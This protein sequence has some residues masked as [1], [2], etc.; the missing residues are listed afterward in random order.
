GQ[1]AV[2][3]EVD[4]RRTRYLESQGFRVIRFWNNQ[5]MENLEG[6]LKEIELILLEMRVGVFDTLTESCDLHSGLSDRPSPNPSRR[7]EGGLDGPRPL[8]QEGK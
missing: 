4:A 8:T 3:A 7:R 1:H 2:A 6:V 5:V